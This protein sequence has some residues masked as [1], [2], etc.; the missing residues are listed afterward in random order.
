[1]SQ[2]I[3]LLI[4]AGIIFSSIQKGAM[5][6]LSM[7][8]G[9]VL[10]FL[11]VPVLY[12]PIRNVVESFISRDMLVQGVPN[13]IAGTYVD[14]VLKVIVFS[15]IFFI[16]RRV[17]AMFFDASSLSQTGR[18]IDKIGGVGIGIVKVMMLCWVFNFLLSASNNPVNAAIENFLGQSH[19]YVALSNFNLIEKL[20]LI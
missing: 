15:V 7:L 16:A 14:V 11:G 5:R 19:L 3:I 8:C 12:A 6:E 17:S 13:S 18:V 20:L 10:G 2:F 1:M 4:F 9:T